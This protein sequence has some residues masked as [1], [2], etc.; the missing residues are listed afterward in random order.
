M[1]TFISITN[2]RKL[3]STNRSFFCFYTTASLHSSSAHVLVVNNSVGEMK[4]HEKSLHQQLAKQRGAID[5]TSI[6]LIQDVQKL[7]DL[8]HRKSTLVQSAKLK[9]EQLEAMKDKLSLLEYAMST[10][11][12]KRTCI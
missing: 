10:P 2:I 11:K 12:E 7:K 9:A 5:I 1:G 4:R 3:L 8:E 6:N